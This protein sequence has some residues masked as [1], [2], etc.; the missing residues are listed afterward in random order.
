L[1]EIS[2]SSEEYYSEAVKHAPMVSGETAVQDQGTGE[3]EIFITNEDLW[4]GNRM[5]HSL[6]NNNQLKNF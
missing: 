6:I 2:I 5:N 4:R 1:S 3:I